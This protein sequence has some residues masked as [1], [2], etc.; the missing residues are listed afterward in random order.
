[1][2]DVRI[3]LR[4]LLRKYRDDTQVDALKEG[5]VLLVQELMEAEVKE[6]TPGRAVRANKEPT[7][8]PQWVPPEAVGHPGGIGDA[9]DPQGPTREL[10]P[11]PSGTSPTDGEGPAGRSP[12]GL[13]ARGEHAEGGR[14]CPGPG[15]R[16]D[17]PERGVQDL[18][19]AG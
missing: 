13:R 7:H 5:L 9:P 12:G 1:M 10:L 14:P 17:L 4:E 16:G 18:C 15:D 6:K 2:A 11:K 8:V 19:C 3:A